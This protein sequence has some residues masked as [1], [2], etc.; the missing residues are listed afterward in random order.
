M[1]KNFKYRSFLASMAVGVVSLSMSALPTPAPDDNTQADY[2]IRS[3]TPENCSQVTELSSIEILYDTHPSGWSPQIS[4]EYA[5]DLW[6]PENPYKKL[7]VKRKGKT[8]STLSVEYCYV[9][10]GPTTL[11]LKFNLDTPQ[12]A[13]GTYEIVIPDRYI[14]D[15]SN[16]ST[17]KQTL[18]YQIGEGDGDEDPDPGPGPITGQFHLES[19]TPMSGDAVEELSFISAK[20]LDSNDEPCVWAGPSTLLLQAKNAEGKYFTVGKAN[21]DFGNGS[22][23][24]TLNH[25][26]SVFGTAYLTIPV[27]AIQSADGKEKNEEEIPLFFPI[28][29]NKGVSMA[30]AY[31][32]EFTVVDGKSGQSMESVALIYGVN[33]SLGQG[34]QPYL[35]DEQGDITYSDSMIIPD[36]DRTSATIR[37]NNADML[38]KGR[39][40]VVVPR[41]AVDGSAGVAFYYDF[42]PIPGQEIPDIPDGTK[43]EFVKCMI[44]NYDLL[45]PDNGIP[46]L[47][48][49][50]M[51][52]LSTTLDYASDVYW[53]KILDVTDCKSED[54]YDRA[55]AI[56]SSY[57]DKAGGEFYGEIL[58][59]GNVVRNLTSD[60]LYCVEVIAYLNY[61]NAAMRKEWGNAFSA[62]FRGGAAPYE[63]QDCDV[64]VQPMPGM[65]LTKGT[66]VVMTF[67]IPVNFVDRNSGIPQGQ[68]GTLGLSASSNADKTVWTFELPEGAFADSKLEVHFGFTDASTGKRIR[69]SAHNVPETEVNN[70]YIFNYGTEGESQIVVIYES[71]EGKPEFKVV[72]APGSTLDKLEEF[73]Y[74]FSDN[75]AIMPS[76]MGEAV[77]RD[78]SGNVV[79]HLLA[80]NLEENGGHVKVDYDNP[81]AANAKAL[82]LHMI[83]DRPVVEKGTYTV[84][85]PYGYFSKGTE[86]ESDF[87]RPAVHEYVLT[88]LGTVGVGEVS[89]ETDSYTVVSLQ[90]ITLMRNASREELRSLPAGIYIV[91][92]KKI[93]Y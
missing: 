19:M 10:Y 35:V 8:V 87:T 76:W 18:R 91:N 58:A 61:Y 85:Y 50:A 79:A 48:V 28:F 89:A 29:Y 39:Y 46:C 2:P 27:G 62:V 31:P 25:A 57:F 4:G 84:E 26:Y 73:T 1:K 14:V 37:F 43:P 80:D 13:D 22:V 77:V 51:L 74:N 49:G 24:F 69:P 6:N 34:D 65:E 33:V 70:Y 15:G 86:Y 52:R 66:P 63:Y 75:D 7:E 41:N 23:F 3:V 54:E 47:R 67:S 90:G 9:T 11:N 40:T 92:G 82:A 55:P 17:G 38:K 16:Y 20:W 45:D 72:P 42:V 60:R 83:L 78:A 81:N 71:F 64:R 36:M 30:Y 93:R 88:G 44:D 32:N 5:P 56:H 21:V 12:T 53:Y 68:D 59:P